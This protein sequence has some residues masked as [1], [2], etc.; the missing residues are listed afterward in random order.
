MKQRRYGLLIAIQA[1]RLENIDALLGEIRDA[2]EARGANCHETF[3]TLSYEGV[4][5][6]TEGPK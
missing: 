3:R 4:A 1:E 2:I 6:V 5:I